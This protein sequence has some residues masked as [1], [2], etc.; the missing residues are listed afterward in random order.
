M[1]PNSSGEESLVI[2]PSAYESAPFSQPTM[3][4]SSL[5]VPSPCTPG[6]SVERASSL[7]SASVATMPERSLSVVT[8]VPSESSVETPWCAASLATVS[9][10]GS[11]VLSASSA[12][13]SKMTESPVPSKN[14]TV[15]PA[16]GT[17]WPAFG[18]S[19]VTPV[20]AGCC[21]SRTWKPASVVTSTL[22]PSPTGLTRVNPS[23][24]TSPTTSR[25]AA[26]STTSPPSYVSVTRSEAGVE[27]EPAGAAASPVAAGVVWAQPV[28][29]RMPRAVAAMAP[30]VLEGEAMVMETLSVL[31][32]C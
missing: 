17:A 21:V 31:W 11:F 16:W 14:S 29:A 25:V 8:K 7:P 26:S 22:R 19:N 15:L 32:G 6:Q 27:A 2:V 1:R 30:R 23:M 9:V 24:G 20:S 5:T 4:T 10:S 18:P 28:R 13:V 12:S 3:T